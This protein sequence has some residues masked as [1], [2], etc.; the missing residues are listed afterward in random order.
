MATIIIG[1]PK[2]EP[3]TI[4]GVYSENVIGRK[5]SKAVNENCLDQEKYPEYINLAMQMAIK[6]PGK[7]EGPTN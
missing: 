6:Y 7:E 1:G 2:G 3:T 4:H 5:T